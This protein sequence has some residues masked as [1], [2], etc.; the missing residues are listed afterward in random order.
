MILTI[1]IKNIKILKM[2]ITFLFFS[3][4]VKSSV[5]LK[6]MSV[7]LQDADGLTIDIQITDKGDGTFVCV[8]VPI[9]PIKHTIIITWGGVNI[10]N[11]PFRVRDHNENGHG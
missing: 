6:Y 8:Y 9:K 2:Y 3:M 4:P 5:S 10:P 7:S 11:S 1:F